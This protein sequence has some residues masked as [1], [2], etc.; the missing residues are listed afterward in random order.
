M[1]CRRARRTPR[2]PRAGPQ[3]GREQLRPWSP[4][5]SPRTT[6]RRGDHPGSAGH[7]D[8]PAASAW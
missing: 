8:G 6:R 7:P 4:A 3:T 5:E 2:S 1:G